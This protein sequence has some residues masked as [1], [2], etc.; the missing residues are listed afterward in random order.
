MAVLVPAS[1]LAG[2]YTPLARGY[3]IPLTVA[4]VL[5]PEL[6]GNVHTR[7]GTGRWEP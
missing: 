4:V 2:E 3:W 7:C 5:R 1:A 6:H